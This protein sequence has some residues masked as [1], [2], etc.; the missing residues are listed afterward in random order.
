LAPTPLAAQ[1]AKSGVRYRRAG[2]PSGPPA[3]FLP[4]AGWTG[5]E[6]L[7]VAQALPHL[8]W[9][10]LD[11]PGTGGSLP[12]ERADAPGFTRWLGAFCADL[13]LGDVHL[14]G[15]SLGGYLALAAA[16]SGRMGLRSLLLIDGGLVPIAV[17]QEIGKIAYAAPFVAALDRVTGGAVVARRPGRPAPPEAQPEAEAVA[18]R[19]RV[20]LS[21]ALRAAVEDLAAPSG[22]DWDLDGAAVQRL[23]MIGVR[24]FGARAL[25]RVTARVLALVALH[26]QG[27]RWAQRLKQ[28][29]LGRLGALCATRDLQVV[30]LATGHYPF[31]EDPAQFAAAVRPFYAEDP[32]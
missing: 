9:Y 5:A 16:A 12:L 13:G 11:L 17:P 30:T 4:G 7:S 18:G 27:P 14:A 1:A 24:T 28:K 26:P 8:S 32:G 29:A 19:F 25:S 22:R 2:D 21:D 15:H 10:L 3:L 6:G 23:G 20:P 31:W